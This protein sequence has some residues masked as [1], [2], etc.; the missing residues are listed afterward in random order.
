[1]FPSDTVS[2]SPLFLTLIGGLL[3]SLFFFF[4]LDPLSAFGPL[5][6]YRR[7][8]L[9]SKVRVTPAVI[10]PVPSHLFWVFFFTP[11]FPS[12]PPCISFRDEGLFDLFYFP[13]RFWFLLRRGFLIFLLLL[14]HGPWRLAFFSLSI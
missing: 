10:C 11:V 5:N 7:R 1:V 12:H 8:L 13:S 9:S 2:S 4:F 14:V 6:S 3:M